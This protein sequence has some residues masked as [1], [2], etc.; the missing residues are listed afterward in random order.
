MMLDSNPLFNKIR[1]ELNLSKEMRNPNKKVQ[2]YI[3]QECS[4]R[5]LLERKQENVVY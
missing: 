4:S 2:S 1:S 5:L 3:D